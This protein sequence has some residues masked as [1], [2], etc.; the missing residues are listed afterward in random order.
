VRTFDRLLPVPRFQQQAC[1]VDA[2]CHRALAKIHQ[3]S[4]IY[5]FCYAAMFGLEHFRQNAPSANGMQDAFGIFMYFK[6]I[7]YD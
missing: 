6:G 7:N 1:S 2:E 3:D 5:H 4:L